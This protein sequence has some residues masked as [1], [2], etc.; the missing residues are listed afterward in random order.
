MQ[1]TTLFTNRSFSH[2]KQNAKKRWGV[3]VVTC[4]VAALPLAAPPANAGSSH[5]STGGL[6]RH[7]EPSP[8]FLETLARKRYNK[9]NKKAWEATTG[10]KVDV[11]VVHRP[12]T[13]KSAHSSHE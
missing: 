2:E 6:D 10:R 12:E 1:I 13:A 9:S 4:V 8:G 11:D 5:S 3:F 7:A